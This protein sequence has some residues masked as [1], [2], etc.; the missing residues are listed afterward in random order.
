MNEQIAINYSQSVQKLVYVIR[1]E[2]ASNHEIR[3]HKDHIEES[4]TIRSHFGTNQSFMNWGLWEE[5]IYQD[6]RR[7]NMNFPTTCLQNIYS[8]FLLFYLIRPLIPMRFFNKR[9]LD[10]GCG[11]G[12]GIKLGAQMLKS[13]YALGV[14]LT[15]QM[16]RNAH[17]DVYP[18][19]RLHYIQGDS[20]HLP[21]A[22]ESFDIITNLESS[23]LYPR[24]EDFFIEVD[25]ILAPGGFFCYADLH[26][27]NRSQ[28]KKLT[29]F[30]EKKPHLSVIEKQDITKMVQASIFQRMIVHED[31]Y[32]QDLQTFFRQDPAQIQSEI[33]A[34]MTSDGLFFLPKWKIKFNNPMLDNLAE[35][36][37]KNDAW[38]EPYY[39]YYL[40]YKKNRCSIV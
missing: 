34:R 1:H 26:V 28:T 30:L 13:Q 36:T 20:E 6:Y 4:Y 24:I 23:H 40:I 35:N 2:G 38:G 16:V 7:L 10:I 14:D 11:Y 15:Y 9:L 39:F 27:N 22:D 32:Y 29:E 12:M 17:R 37:R 8:Q 31:T 18:V 25:R 3:H 5:K 21:L 19:N 33:L